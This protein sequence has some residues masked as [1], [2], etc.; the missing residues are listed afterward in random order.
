MEDISLEKIDIIRDRTG[1]TYREA[2]EALVRNQ[3]NVLDALIE[4]E[5]KKQCTWTEEIS[6]KSNEVLERVK[7]LIR[8]GNVR[9]IRV[10][11]EGRVIA[12]IPV[13]LGA[14]GAVV[15]PQL[16]VLGVLV[17]VFKNCTLEVVRE[18]EADNVAHDKPPQPPV[19]YD[20]KEPP[21]P[22]L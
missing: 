17:A 21:R 5:S 15:V 13:T 2:K 18:G 12:D 19:L 3:G 14:I 1:V 22:I 4:L 6:V 7:T 11:H 20:D 10:K 16:A 8:E 9:K